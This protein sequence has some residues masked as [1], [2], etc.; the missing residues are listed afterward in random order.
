M[1]LARVVAVAVAI[2]A[3]AAGARMSEPDRLIWLDLV[4]KG[5]IYELRSTMLGRDL[6]IPVRIHGRNLA[7]AALCI[8]GEPPQP[9]TRAVLDAFRLLMREVHGRAL[10][11]RYAGASARACGTGRVAV[12]RLWSGRPP[13]A[14]LTE[15]LVWMD[16]IHGL[17]LPPQRSYA[18]HSPAMAQTFF[19]RRGSGTHLMVKQAAGP[20]MTALEAAFY[21]SILVEELFQAFTFGMDILHFDRAAPFASKLEEYPVNLANLPWN[22]PAFMEGLLRSNPP[23]LCDFDVFMLHAVA[24]APVEQT[25]EAAFLDFVT[26]EFE[27]LL[28][29][30]RRTLADARIALIHD[31][32]CRGPFD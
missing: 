13:N 25:T 18:A 4:Q 6:S 1:I 17:G 12:L 31:P 16:A 32:D 21:R 2:W 20:E 24:R 3:T 11:M 9:Q 19:G 28:A 26:A 29:A 15:D 8:V 10:P 23:G 22:S 27:P 5:W 14:A 30:A 7:G